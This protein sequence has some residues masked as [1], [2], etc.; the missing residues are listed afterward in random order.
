MDDDPSELIEM[1][2]E[3]KSVRIALLTPYTGGNLGDASIQ[4]AVIANLRRRLPTAEFS[5]IS[6]NCDNFVRRHGISGFPLLGHLRFDGLL[7]GEEWQPSSARNDQHT[8]YAVQRKVSPIR[9]LR[10]LLG[11]IPGLR[12]SVGA[13]RRAWTLLSRMPRELEHSRAGYS[14]VRSHDVIVV[15]GGGQLTEEW[16][17]PWQHPFNLFKWALLARIA[18]VPCVVLGVGVGKLESVT[19]KIFVFAALHLACYR[20][21]RNE[22]TKRIVRRFLGCPATD[23]VVPDLAFS[24]QPCDLPPGSGLRKLARSR[25]IV[26]VSP[27]AYGKPRMWWFE[28]RDT[29]NHFVTEMAK[30]TSHLLKDDWFVIVVYSSLGDDESVIPEVLEL[31]DDD[32]KNRMAAQLRIAEIKTWKDLVS[33]LRETDFLVASRLHSTILGMISGI[34]TIAISSG[35]KVDWVMEDIGQSD[36]LLKI[37]DFTAKD[38]IKCLS[39]LASKRNRIVG[40]INSYNHRAL[41]VSQAQYDAVAEVARRR[42]VR[43]SEL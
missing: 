17:G 23:A 38:I 42:I 34:P 40:E 32:A 7:P 35:S 24:L 10:R 12:R 6:M 26:A 36:Y 13:A 43:R 4:D 15:S 37:R 20:T 5:G 11:R 30:L 14:F 18:R 16:G 1:K 28:D 33:T 41:Y 31:I 22:N 27:I 3:Q 39:N 21:Y 9:N 19:S 29:Y 8:R 2:T 25:R